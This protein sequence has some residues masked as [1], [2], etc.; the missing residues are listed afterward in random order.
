[1]EKQNKKRHL[2]IPIFLPFVGCKNHCIYCNQRLLHP[3]NTELSETAFDNIIMEYTNTC[4]WKRED[5]DIE[6]AFYGGSFTGI[7]RK[8]Q[9][10]VLDY[11]QKH[12]RDHKIDG[13]RFSTRPDMID[14]DLLKIY[15]EMAVKTIEIGAQSFNDSVLQSIKRG[16][17]AQDTRESITLLKSYEFRTSIHLMFGLPGST[18][19]DDKESIEET[20]RLSPDYVRIHPT[21][22]LKGTELE[23]LYREGRYKPLEI[24][25]AVEIIRYALKGFEDADIKVIR[26]GLHNDE[27]LAN[28]DTVVAGPFHP[29]LRTLA[30]QKNRG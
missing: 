16:H 25:E 1:M 14:A 12:I 15:R 19:E 6:V 26:V 30:E 20:I 7:E 22:V 18:I 9:I 5:T 17:S 10:E 28:P 8:M 11:L 23:R 27:Y 4:R 2:I 29:S 24:Y 13:I 21:L 3:E